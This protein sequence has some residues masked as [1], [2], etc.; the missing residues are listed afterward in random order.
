M[1]RRLIL[2]WLGVPG[3]AQHRHGSTEPVNLP[4][5]RLHFPAQRGVVGVALRAMHHSEFQIDKAETSVG[6]A[7]GP[8]RR[9]GSGAAR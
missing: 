3:A 8:Q 1:I 5:Q 6:S 2:R 9:P 4:A 7:H